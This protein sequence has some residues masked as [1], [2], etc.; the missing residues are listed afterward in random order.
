[1]EHEQDKK[2]VKDMLMKLTKTELVDLLFE[3][4][5]VNYY[6]STVK[7][8]P[9]PRQYRSIGGVSVPY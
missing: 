5:V 6:H 1:M 3:S 7:E 4:M 2:K 8:N 9:T